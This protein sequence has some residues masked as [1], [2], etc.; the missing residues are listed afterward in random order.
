MLRFTITTAK[1]CFKTKIYINIQ[2]DHETQIHMVFV[3]DE[4]NI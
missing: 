3:L 4:A 2:L 1:F